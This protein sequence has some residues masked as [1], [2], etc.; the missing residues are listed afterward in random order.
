MAALTLGG[1]ALLALAASLIATPA[2]AQARPTATS[3]MAA[4]TAVETDSATTGTDRDDGEDRSPWRQWQWSGF[5][6]LAANHHDSR[7]QGVISAFSQ[8]R[9]AEQGFSAHLDT[10]GGVQ[11]VWQPVT[12]SS[13][14]LQAVAR[15]A[16]DFQPA[17]RMAFLRQQLPQ[18][19]SL[20]L[21]RLR[22]PMFFDSD[23]TEIGYANLTVR[24]AVALYGSVGSVAGLDGGDL[25]WHH[26]LAGATLLV[27]AWAGRYDYRHRFYNLDPVD[28]AQARLSGI[29]GLSASL[30]WPWLTVRASHTRV[31]RMT[32][33][34]PVTGALDAALGQLAGG[35]RQLAADPRLPAGTAAALAAQARGVDGLQQVYDS[36][37]RY[38]SLG[39][40]A[41]HGRWRLLGEWMR[42][43]TRSAMD[44][45]YQGGQLTLGYSRGT[46]TPYLGAARLHRSSA[47]LDLG[48]LQATGL[49]PTLDAGLTHTQAGLALARGYADIATRSATLGLRWDG[50]DTWALKLQADRLRAD[51]AS[52]AG[53]LALRGLPQG[54]PVR[55][56]T[57]ALDMVF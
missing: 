7:T 31:S 49:D 55:L 2:R 12:G 19:V 11:G 38:T 1:T 22:S 56:I 8:R 47:D 40:D 50:G 51:Q 17:W 5:A 3:P 44:G 10:V 37:P 54:Q 39:L 30:N 48:A 46:L 36:Q 6:T 21:G 15:A 16:D 42:L 9:P 14:H 26:E 13:L 33:R 4:T 53:V 20:R 43:D 57:L 24:P 25:Q 28:V 29:R 32:L 27:Q 23:I 45:A 35:L 41:S 52:G 18:G 34:S